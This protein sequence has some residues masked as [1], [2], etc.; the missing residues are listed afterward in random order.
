MQNIQLKRGL[1]IPFD[2]AAALT[3]GSVN[4][5]AVFHIV[6]D[7]FAGVTPKL[8]VQTVSPL[9][10]GATWLICTPTLPAG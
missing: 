1:D 4:R 2:G 10:I 6:P 5:P 3:L 7:H 9:A 8:M